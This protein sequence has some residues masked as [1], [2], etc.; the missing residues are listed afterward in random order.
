MADRHRVIQPELL[1]EHFTN[2]GRHIRIGR[3]LLERIARRQRQHREQDD[4]DA[5]DAR[6]G[7]QE[8]S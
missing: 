3:E 5:E 2:L 1:P 4:A 8:A 6:D 7:D